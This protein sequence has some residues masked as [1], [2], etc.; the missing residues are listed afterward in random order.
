MYE[1]KCNKS[2]NKF[3]ERKYIPV[4]GKVD[5]KHFLLILL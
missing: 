2:E 1:D 4:Y 3:E 5:T